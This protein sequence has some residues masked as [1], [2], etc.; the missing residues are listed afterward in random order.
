MP[1]VAFLR[2]S[3]SLT[4]KKEINIVRGGC[5]PILI[6]EIELE[7]SKILTHKLKFELAVKCLASGS[8]NPG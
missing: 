8:S 4:N 3:H 1:C 7:Q 6:H 2:G 5:L